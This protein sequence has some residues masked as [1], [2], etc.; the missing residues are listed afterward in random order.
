MNCVSPSKFKWPK[1]INGGKCGFSPYIAF[2]CVVFFF[3][4]FLY[5]SDPVCFFFQ[6]FFSIS[7]SLVSHFFPRKVIDAF[8]FI[9]CVY[10]CMCVF[11]THIC[12]SVSME[13]IRFFYRFFP[14]L[15]CFYDFEIIC[16]K[17]LAAKIIRAYS[18]F[19]E[20]ILW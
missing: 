12:I 5:P 7:G 20:V 4:W 2:P 9:V 11:N 19:G 8:S 6:I 10:V 14:S 15:N 13:W 18:L 3:L 16:L 1:G 17:V